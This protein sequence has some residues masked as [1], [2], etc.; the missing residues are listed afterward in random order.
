[1]DSPPSAIPGFKLGRY[2]HR[3]EVV[4]PDTA[5]RECH[6]EDERLLREFAARYFPDGTGPVLSMAT[7][8]FTNTPDEHFVVD[9]CRAY[10][11]WWW[12]RP[13]RGMVLSSPA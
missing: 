10:R 11:K 2:H 8:L 12:R 9:L 1:M 5:D 4:D 7:C 13:A 6:P 3:N